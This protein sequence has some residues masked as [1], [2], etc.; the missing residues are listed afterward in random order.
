MTIRALS[1]AAT[2]M[3]AQQLNVDVI[4]NNLAN[5]NTTGF[6]KSRAN[7]QDLIYQTLQRAGT[8]LSADQDNQ[9]PNGVQIGLGVRESSVQKIF[10]Q[11]PLSNTG[12]QTD[13]AIDG[14]GFFQV[15]VLDNQAPD[16][17]A[18][19]RTGAFS[20][21][22]NGQVVT[23]NGYL[24]EPPITVPENTIA[25][26]VSIDGRV[27]AIQQDVAEATQIGTIQLATFR[28]PSGLQ[29]QGDS[30][31][32]QTNAS[33]TAQVQNPGQA[34]TGILRQNFLEQSNVQVVQELVDLI[35]AQRA[36]EVN[37]NSIETADEMLQTANNLRR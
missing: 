37:A 24:L 3:L 9:R 5:V 23:A 20:I 30:L 14:E 29:G 35:Q 2:G 12:V 1:T 21:D 8:S 32:V 16:G 26:N 11:G 19:T 25:I 13:I 34:G 17:I 31:Y 27:E 33:G 18:Y 4:S 22:Q 6:K 36:Y 7:F 28:N 15:K 10:L